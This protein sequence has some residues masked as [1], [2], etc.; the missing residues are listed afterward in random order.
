MIDAQMKEKIAADFIRVLETSEWFGRTI[1][2]TEVREANDHFDA[3]M[4][5]DAAFRNNGINPLPDD[6]Q[7]SQEATDLWNAAWD[8]A[9]AI[10]EVRP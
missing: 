6:E 1:T 10:K 9:I 7:M 3:N 2:A 4:A 5:M 8:R